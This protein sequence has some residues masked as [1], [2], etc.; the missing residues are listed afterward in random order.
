MYMYVHDIAIMLYKQQECYAQ[1]NCDRTDC[2]LM[3]SQPRHMPATGSFNLSPYYVVL[4]VACR[5]QVILHGPRLTDRLACFALVIP[6]C[7]C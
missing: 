7:T 2:F 6:A 5:L 1:D 3:Y 4:V